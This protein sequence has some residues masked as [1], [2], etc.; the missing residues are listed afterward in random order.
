[1]KNEAVETSASAEQ[2]MA[3]KPTLSIV[4]P[5]YNE[6]KNI[7][8]LFES[9]TRVLSQQKR[10]YEIIAV[11]DGSKDQSVRALRDSAAKEKSIRVI[12]LRTNFGQ[13]A[14]LSAGIE[15]A[16]GDIIVSIDSDLENDPKDIEKLLEKIDEGYDVVSGWRQD[17]WKGSLITRRVP[18]VVANWLI[19]RLTGLRLNDYGCT[20]KAY[21]ANVIKDVKLYGE[22]HRFIPAYAAWQ[23]GKVAELPVSYKPR[24]YGKSNYG[25]GRVLRVLLDLIVV[26]FLHRYFN[27][28]I[29]FF[30]GWGVASLIAGF[31]TLAAALI[32]RVTGGPT[33]IETPLPTLAALF[34][35]VGVQVTLFGVLAEILMRTYY[36]SQNKRPYILK[37]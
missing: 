9:L 28:P 31:L 24:V 34:V 22:M 2:E 16:M 12:E 26:V 21:R 23:G 1:M 4:L 8:I 19:S 5:V 30:G 32:I 29:H 37:K 3:Q 18:S 17:R 11:D 10:P 20:L 6:E 33:L 13:T 25:I 36:E 35:I 15:H 27:R 14:A 7:P